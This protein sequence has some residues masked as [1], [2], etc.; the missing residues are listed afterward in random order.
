MGAALSVVLAGS[1]LVAGAAA[2]ASAAGAELDQSNIGPLTSGRVGS[3]DTYLAQ[4]FTA[5]ITGYLDHIY[6][7][8]LN[9]SAT[10]DV[11]V[12]A[13]PDPG[14]PIAMGRLADENVEFASRAFLLANQTYVLA[15]EADAGGGVGW[16][17]TSGN[18]YTRGLS[19]HGAVSDW[20]SISIDSGYDYIFSTYVEP[21]VLP[22]T[23][24]VTNRDYEH[25]SSATVTW[26]PAQDATLDTRY[27]LSWGPSSTDPSTWSQLT[28]TTAD[29]SATLPMPLSVPYTVQVSAVAYGRTSAAATV[30]TKAVP[31]LRAAYLAD[32]DA[33]GAPGALTVRVS[34]AGATPTGT[35]SFSGGGATCAAVPLVGDAAQ[36]R[37]ASTSATPTTVRAAYTGD[38]AYAAAATSIEVGGATPTTG[39]PTTTLPAA[40]FVVSGARHVVAVGQ[41]LRVRASGLA[42][43]EAFTVT[44][45]GKVAGR[46][47]ADASGRI[48]TKVVPRAAGRTVT[49]IGS[50]ADRRGKDTV[51]VVAKKKRLLVTTDADPWVGSHLPVAITVRGLAAHES[52]VVHYRGTRIARGHAN[53]SGVFVVTTDA[54]FS[55]GDHAVTARGAAIGRRGSATVEVVRRLF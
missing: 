18:A 42:P 33:V 10:A 19:G 8:S 46:G 9:P 52:V 30:A 13:W 51:S 45:G 40:S 24:V 20:P 25:A 37:F 5:G 22:P 53:A 47:T 54:G 49:V 14:A 3:H 41:K 27:L 29:A 43:S 36:C 11:T 35:V 17:W 6:L 34:G 1:G 50:L 7:P 21:A 15:V 4:T 31:A 28:T 23:A 48:D 32:S 55:W 16:Y 39:A 26:T 12:Y 2:P 44:V 38:A